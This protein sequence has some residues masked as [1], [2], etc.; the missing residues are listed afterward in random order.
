MRPVD[1]TNWLSFKELKIRDAIWS[2]SAN[3][4]RSI[5]EGFLWCEIWKNIEWA[6]ILKMSIIWFMWFASKKSTDSNN[7]RIVLKNRS[8]LKFV[9][10]TLNLKAMIRTK[11]RR[12]YFSNSSNWYFHQKKTLVIRWMIKY[13]SKMNT[14]NQ[15]H[16]RFVL[17][18]NFRS[19][20][21]FYR[22]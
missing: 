13:L 1:N 5:S 9:Q 22:H 6:S 7:S 2:Y 14:R 12:S 16:K 19:K 11:L 10:Q 18:K 8:F 21:I 4:F 17:I 20:M 15:S 3:H